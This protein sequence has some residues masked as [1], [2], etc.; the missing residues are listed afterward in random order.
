MSRAHTTVRVMSGAVLESL[1]SLFPLV[2]VGLLL[3][4]FLVPSMACGSGA[5]GG[6]DASSD[7]NVVTDGRTVDGG[8]VVDAGEL[9]DAMPTDAYV[10]TFRDCT[11]GDESFVR[12]TYLAVLG[13]RPKSSTEVAVYT[14]LMTEVRA[15]IE[16]GHNVP[17]PER[18]VVR[19]L[20]DQP[21][22]I[23]RWA[24]HMMDALE[25]QRIEDQTM[26][27]CYNN[28]H[29]VIDS[30]ELARFVRD[31]PGSSGGDGS[32]SFTMLDL[33]RSALVLDDVSPV[34]RAHL[35]TLVSRAIVAANVPPVQA[36]IARREDFGLVFGS[37]YLNRDIVC[38][39]CHNSESSVTYTSDPETN[40]HWAMPGLFEKSLYGVSTGI[41]PERAHA[42]F[43]YDGFV[44]DPFAGE[45]GELRPWD[46]APAC[47]AFSLSGL[48]DDPA[49]VEGLFGS[50]SGTRITIYDL[51]AALAS[52]F[53]G[54]AENGLELM[55]AG[56]ISD[57]D[58]A[59]GYLVAAAIVESV[60]EEV[61]GSSLTIANYFPR[62]RESMVLLRQ[63]TDDFIANRF[64]I[65]ELLYDIVTSDYF[66][67]TAP[68]DGCGEDPYNMPPVF[69][70]WVTG[71]MDP[72]RRDNSA[73]DSVAQLSARTLVRTAYQALGWST[74]RFQAFPELPGEY[75]RCRIMECAAMLS[76]CEA[77]H[78]C[79]ATHELECVDPLGPEEP[80]PDEELTFQ[81]EI[82]TF[83]KSAA[84]GFRGL[85]F[86]A[87]LA[88]ERRFGMCAKLSS[89]PDIIDAFT[90][91]AQ[92]ESATMEAV[93]LAVKDRL[94]GEPSI[95]TGERKA[96]ES[97][98]GLAL[99]TP[100][101][102]VP[103][104]D[105]QLRGLCGVL[106]ASPQ[107]LLSGFAPRGGPAPVLILPEASFDS[108]CL[109]LQSR[110][111]AGD[112]ELVCGDDALTLL[113][114]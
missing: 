2:T 66:N 76:S 67:R 79:C 25:V 92:S 52:G 3:G 100:V 27:S 6:G 41:E 46:W 103:D 37:A 89:E 64:S 14:T 28:S 53:D 71:D 57:P 75:N 55:G 15:L 110:G 109:D 38:L 44:A 45:L 97:L 51:E 36:E 43:R 63:F 113:L 68:E 30:G 77:D 108:V 105:A 31:N 21:A 17:T 111:L 16:A 83:L 70:P 72:D 80:T 35:Y 88:W 20:T 24:E 91:L 94:I 98:F 40:R 49:G 34:Y 32:G 104:L 74:P 87:R 5:S 7:A 95:A 107:F 11:A 22:Y 65:R 58:R 73:A 84:R 4:M 78:S 60:W 1:G 26:E 112:L 50:M 56:D 85:D 69:D 47:G 90:T 10:T 33:L 9:A 93:V 99:D 13:Y 114:R 12:N 106:M 82:G 39:G 8:M 59:L 102:L 48:T 62:N 54:L 101:V 29:R 96:L 81:R 18:V 42:P 23:D 86:Q 19:A 61:I